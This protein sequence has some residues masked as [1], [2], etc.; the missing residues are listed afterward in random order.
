MKIAVQFFGH[1]RTYEKCADS[2]KK[3]LISRYDCDVFMHTWTE[4]DHETKTWHSLNTRVRL[5]DVKTIEKIK[6]L[7]ALKDIIVEKQKPIENNVLIP[8]QHNKG[9]SQISKSGMEF[10]IHSQ[11]KVNELRKK[12]QKEN[13]IQY[14]YVL[15]IRPDIKLRKDFILDQIDKEIKKEVATTRYCATSLTYY[16]DFPI[17][18]NVMSDIL[19][20]GRP[21]NIDKTLSV[22]NNI[23]FEKHKND[24]WNPETLFNQELEKSGILSR[25]IN[26]QYKSDWEILRSLNK[27]EFRRSIVRL[28]IRKNLFYFHLFRF[29]SVSLVNLKFYIGNLF[30]IDIG[31]GPDNE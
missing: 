24:M 29:L 27:K 9:K 12:Y 5:I 30:L 2:I 11:K 17:I 15:M 13:H 28:R 4:S 23:D 8:C 14:D 25:F 26:Y 1:L 10:M 6:N 18:G 19:Y 21:K 31:L 7:Y 22:L 16:A 3:H 20:F